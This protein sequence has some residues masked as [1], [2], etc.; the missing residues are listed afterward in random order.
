MH[1]HLGEVC[2]Q[3]LA[4]FH[5]LGA[6]SRSLMRLRRSR[7]ASCKSRRSAQRTNSSDA[8]AV[9]INGNIHRT[10]SRLVHTFGASKC[11]G[12][13]VWEGKRFTVLV[14][15]YDSSKIGE[16]GTPPTNRKSSCPLLLLACT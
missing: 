14:F 3:S 13:T 9:G 12:Y 15:T 2:P 5:C 8:T 7:F 1:P 4:F 16:T 6:R 11:V 10:L